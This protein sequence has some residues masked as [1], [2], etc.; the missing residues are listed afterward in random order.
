MTKNAVEYPKGWW[1]FC[2]QLPSCLKILLKAV[3]VRNKG[4]HLTCCEQSHSKEDY[5]MREKFG[6]VWHYLKSILKILISLAHQI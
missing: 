4:F 3:A 5:F 1:D 2:T 6:F